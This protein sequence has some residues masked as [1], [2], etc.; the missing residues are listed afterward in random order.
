[1]IRLEN[2]VRVRGRNVGRKRSVENWINGDNA[3]RDGFFLD[4]DE[5]LDFRGFGSRGTRG[6]AEE[7]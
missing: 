7:W 1:L 6:A 4:G 2:E 3:T 5:G